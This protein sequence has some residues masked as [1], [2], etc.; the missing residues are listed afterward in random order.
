[1]YD[2]ADSALKMIAF[3][4]ELNVDLG[5]SMQDSVIPSDK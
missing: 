2:A 5:I 1:M 3:L 4:G